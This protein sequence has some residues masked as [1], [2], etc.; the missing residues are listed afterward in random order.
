MYT[1]IVVFQ[2]ETKV[3]IKIGSVPTHGGCIHTLVTP[4]PSNIK[5]P[6]NKQY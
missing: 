2:D 3:M 1:H 6:N 5:R 4:Y